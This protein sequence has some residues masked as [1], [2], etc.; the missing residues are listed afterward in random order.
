M[1]R[2]PGA[3][4]G[5]APAPAGSSGQCPSRPAPLGPA[6]DRQAHGRAGPGQGIALPGAAGTRF[7]LW[8]VRRLPQGGV[9]RSPRCAHR[10]SRR[11]AHSHPPA[12]RPSPG[13][14]AART[15]GAQLR[16]P[17]PIGGL[18]AGGGDRRRRVDDARR[19]QH[20]AQDAGGTALLHGVCA[21]HPQRLRRPAHHPLPLPDRAVPPAGHAPGYSGTPAAP[22]PGRGGREVLRRTR[23]GQS[24]KGPADGRR[25]GGT[26]SARGDPSDPER[27]AAVRR[28]PGVGPG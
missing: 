11:Q 17:A 6:G 24:G 16:R 18:L 15:A 27:V 5:C 22:E 3:A 20:P 4:P 19:R 28:P 10:R 21:D 9:R 2:G 23:R 7:V 12:G 25:R 14:G 13:A 26:T 8:S 1:G